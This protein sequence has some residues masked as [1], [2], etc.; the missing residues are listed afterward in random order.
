MMRYFITLLAYVA[1]A[2]ILGVGLATTHQ[3]WHRI[4]ILG[5]AVVL[6]VLSMVISKYRTP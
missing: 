1:G 3:F 6:I 2:V 4:G 5:A